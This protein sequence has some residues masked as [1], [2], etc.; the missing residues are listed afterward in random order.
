ML[1]NKK[2]VTF[3]FKKIGLQESMFIFLTTLFGV[4]IIYSREENV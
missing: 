4:F 1:A 2:A 3:C